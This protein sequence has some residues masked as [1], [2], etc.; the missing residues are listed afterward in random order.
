MDIGVSNFYPNVLTNFCEN[1]D[2][3]PAVNQI[4]LHPYFQQ[5]D[6]LDTMKYYDVLPEAWAPLG[7]GRYSPFE[8]KLLQDI[9]ETHDKTVGQVV[10]R[11]NIQRGVVVIPKT[12]H[13]ERM[14]ENINVWDF[15]LSQ[16]EM[17]SISTLD[18][19]YGGSRTKHFDP[20]FVR[21]VLGVEIH[22]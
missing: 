13:K 20:E 11:W 5:P 4:E 2:I 7:G 21:S 14:I 19:G 8:E 10:L 9:A 12:T 3:K 16:D 17:E 15:E 1:V 22:G 18:L 6:A